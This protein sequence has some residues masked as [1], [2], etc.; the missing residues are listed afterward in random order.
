MGPTAQVCDERLQKNF[1]VV[2]NM[3]KAGCIVKFAEE[4]NGGSGIYNVRSG[5]YTAI[6][7]DAKGYT[8]TLYAKKEEEKTGFARQGA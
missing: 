4:E 7:D 8:L 5:Q 1:L 6:R 3:T 2:K